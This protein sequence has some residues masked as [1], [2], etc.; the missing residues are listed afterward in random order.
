MDDAQ[1][2]K[3]YI[4]EEVNVRQLTTSSEKERWGVQLTVEPD[5]KA[6]GP[7]L[8]KNLKA[9]VEILKA[10]TIFMKSLI[11]SIKN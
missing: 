6:L 4:L 8:G 11:S 2:L 3:N 10:R 5:Y 1:F 7:R 9:G